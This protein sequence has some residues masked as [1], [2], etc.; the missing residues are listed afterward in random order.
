MSEIDKIFLKNNI[1]SALDSVVRVDDIQ[2]DSSNKVILSCLE[3]IIYN[4]A[5]LDY[6]NWSADG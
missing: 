3:N 1:L 6:A 4:I 2:P 5:Q